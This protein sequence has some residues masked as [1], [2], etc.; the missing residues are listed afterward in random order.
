[1]PVVDSVGAID[2]IAVAGGIVGAAG[3]REPIAGLTV[4]R[5]EGLF[6]GRLEVNIIGIF[7]MVLGS[8]EGSNDGS[9]EGSKDKELPPL[10]GLY[11]GP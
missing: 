6:D 4:G 2:G 7:D 10:L 5:T 1:M 9:V 8:Y 11:V 3:R